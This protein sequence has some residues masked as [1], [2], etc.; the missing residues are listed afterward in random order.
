MGQIF[1]PSTNTFSKA[2]IF[3]AAF[4][5]TGL[6]FVLVSYYRSP[7]QT[8]VGVAIEQPVQFSH[9][10]HVGGLGIDCRYCHTTVEESSF[11]GMPPTHTCMTCHSQIWNQSPALA[12]V[13]QSFETDTPIAWNR[14]NALPDH[15]YFNHS[16]HVQKGVGCTECHG[17]V[18][19]MPLVW[20]SEPFTMEWCL[21]CHREPER[22]LRP[23]EEVYNMAW[24]RP[25]NQ[26]ELGRRLVREYHLNLQR[27]TECYACHR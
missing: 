24:E 23:R 6:A 26:V 15:V 22:F 4:F 3:G 8:G 1:H 9:Q 21:G 13:R 10:H 7:W 11:A 27:L 5:V 14:V 18:D 12:P 2:S 17:R 25:A 20:K 16:I 19:R